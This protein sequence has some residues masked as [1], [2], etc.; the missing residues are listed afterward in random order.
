MSG[1]ERHRGKPCVDCGKAKGPNQQT[2]IRCYRC[3][4]AKRRERRDKAHAQRVEK[5]YGIT[6]DEYGI[7]LAF[8]GGCCAICRRAKGLS[9]RLAVDHDHALEAEQ[10][11]RASVR[12]LLCSPCNDILAHARDDPEFL[13][14]AIDYL[15]NPPSREVLNL[16]Q[17]PQ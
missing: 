17:P 5:T 7:L 16:D 14:R 10:G 1:S 2:D 12:G 11:S 3:G 13:R 9:K 4:L 6:G 15:I 8:Q